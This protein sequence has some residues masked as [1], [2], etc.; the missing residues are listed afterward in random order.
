M[1][2]IIITCGLGASL[3]FQACCWLSMDR[4]LILNKIVPVL[5]KYFHK[6]MHDIWPF[7]MSCIW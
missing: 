1:I 6:V 3:T 5:P 7:C 4:Q 2:V